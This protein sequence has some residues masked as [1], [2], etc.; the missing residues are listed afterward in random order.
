MARSVQD[1]CQSGPHAVSSDSTEL[2]FI[3]SLHLLQTILMHLMSVIFLLWN[4]WA[5]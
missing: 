5:V 3:F 2:R 4:S 1:S